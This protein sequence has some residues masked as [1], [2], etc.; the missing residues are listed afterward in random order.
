[1]G[2]LGA[3]LRLRAAANPAF[4]SLVGVTCEKKE[5]EKAQGKGKHGA[6]PRV[7]RFPLLALQLLG[8]VGGLS[9]RLGAVFGHLGAILGRLEAILA[10]SEA[11]QMASWAVLGHPGVSLEDRW[12]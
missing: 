9:G 11:S 12:V 6:P 3:R 7:V 5:N 8:Y 10:L 2:C 1:M 4:G